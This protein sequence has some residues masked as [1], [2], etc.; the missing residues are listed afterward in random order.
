M[1]F[2]CSCE[3]GFQMNDSGVQTSAA[4]LESALTAAR[5]GIRAC[6]MCEYGITHT[7]SKW[8]QVNGTSHQLFR[9]WDGNYGTEHKQHDILWRLT[10]TI[11][12]WE[13]ESDEENEEYKCVHFWETQ[14]MPSS[15]HGA[16]L[17]SAHS[18]G[19]WYLSSSAL[20]APY[21]ILSSFPSPRN[22]SVR[23]QHGLV[24]MM[25]RGRCPLKAAL[26][27][28]LLCGHDRNVAGCLKHR[29]WVVANWVR[30]HPCWRVIG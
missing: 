10:Q 1:H 27:L 3:G 2:D 13:D 19:A 11:R 14:P 4:D 26:P 24:L 9:G 16:T 25:S 5:H 20:S 23:Q 22:A 18:V 28:P 12:V 30:Q 15:C 21:T 7:L 8:D 6:G 29:V 17:N